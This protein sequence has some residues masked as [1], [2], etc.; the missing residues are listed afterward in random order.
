MFF[1]LFFYT[2]IPGASFP[3]NTLEVSPEI[4]PSQNVAAPPPNFS[5][6]PVFP[7]VSPDQAILVKVEQNSI[8]DASKSVPNERSKTS[9]QFFNVILNCCIG[10]STS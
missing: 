7:W 9:G 2:S 8:T 1:L 4:N 10:A 6:C 5:S 3:L